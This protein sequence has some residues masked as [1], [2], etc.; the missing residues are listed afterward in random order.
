RGLE[1][2]RAAGLAAAEDL[3]RLFELLDALVVVAGVVERLAFV[4][5]PEGSGAVVGGYPVLGRR[6]DQEGVELIHQ[7]RTGVGPRGIGGKQ[8]TDHCDC[9]KSHVPDSHWGRVERHA[10]FTPRG[11]AAAPAGTGS[12]GRLSKRKRR[13]GARRRRQ[14][15]RADFPLA[16]GLATIWT[17]R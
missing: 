4:V 1:R 9:C 5:Q 2:R 6:F 11:S 7:R 3:D 12:K 14:A 13:G 10:V 16:G 8:T 15:A 17:R